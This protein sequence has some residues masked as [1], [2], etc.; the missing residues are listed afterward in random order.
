MGKDETSVPHVAV[1]ELR[2][3]SR[4][5]IDEH[6]EWL[7]GYYDTYNTFFSGEGK[8]DLT[9]LVIA[10]E[11]KYDAEPRQKYIFLEENDTL[12]EGDQFWDKRWDAWHEI[13]PEDVGRVIDLTD[14]IRRKVV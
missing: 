14:M 5:A 8:F 4:R 13:D 1:F 9:T 10:D 3:P 2:G 11:E 6:V 12:Q 7:E